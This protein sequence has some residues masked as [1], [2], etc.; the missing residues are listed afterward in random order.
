MSVH[1]ARMP[2]P[3]NICQ[4]GFGG[5]AAG[6]IGDEEVGE[7]DTLPADNTDY[8]L[9]RLEGHGTI[10]DGLYQWSEANEVWIQV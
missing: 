10:P 6:G 5:S 1:Y 2:Y 8:E 9:F 7:G 4:L 3:T